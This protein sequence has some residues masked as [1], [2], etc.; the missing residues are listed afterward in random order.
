MSVAAWSID[1]PNFT[2]VNVASNAAYLT[3]DLNDVN[4]RVYAV[5]GE[6]S[7]AETQIPVSAMPSAASPDA[8]ATNR[9]RSPLRSDAIPTTTMQIAAMV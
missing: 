1:Q 7:V 5:T 6:D 9:F 2:F 3:S 4:S 8:I